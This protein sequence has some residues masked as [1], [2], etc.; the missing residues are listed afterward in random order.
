MNEMGL[1]VT[2]YLAGMEQKTGEYDGIKKTTYRY[3]LVAGMESFLITSEDDYGGDIAL[4]D[5]VTFIVSPR[6]YGQKIFYSRG[7]LCR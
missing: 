5:V 2:G 1:K 3:L 6:V 4:Q 7:K